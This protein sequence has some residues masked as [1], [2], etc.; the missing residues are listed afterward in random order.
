MNENGPWTIGE[1]SD[2]VLR[3]LHSSGLLEADY[4]GQPS[5]R[6]RAIPDERT[7]RWYSSIGLLDKPT[8]RGRTALYGRRHL[9]QLVA[10][11]RLQAQGRSLSQVQEDLVGATDATLEGI[12]HL[13]AE[14]LDAEFSL[15]PTAAAPQLTLSRPERFWAGEEDDTDTV[16]KGETFKTVARAARIVGGAGDDDTVGSGEGSGAGAEAAQEGASGGK[17]A[18]SAAGAGGGRARAAR[19][20]AA[21]A[22]AG[23][24]PAVRLGAGVTLLLGAAARPLN[25]DDLAR[26]EQA[27]GPL[28]ELLRERGLDGPDPGGTRR[29]EHT[30]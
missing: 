2:L 8:M 16:R 17:V 18:E 25:A 19:R 22:G 14:L 3:V 30:S 1:L 12:A 23:V 6:V 13:P 20:P 5:G 4:A 27:A 11:K 24:V 7:I 29:N 15:H 21:A 10:I 26:L 9:C 28:L